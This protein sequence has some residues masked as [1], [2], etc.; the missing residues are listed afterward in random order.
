LN[1]D[2]PGKNSLAA[3]EKVS[4][5]EGFN[6]S[7]RVRRCEIGTRK[8]RFREVA[9]SKGSHALLFGVERSTF[10][11]PFQALNGKKKKD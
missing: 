9:V 7:I 5:G 1:N 2:Y 6:R 4:L 3:A 8:R 10:L 11:S